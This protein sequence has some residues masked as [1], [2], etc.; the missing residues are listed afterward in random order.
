MSSIL[1]R[2]SY[3]LALDIDERIQ[4]DYGCKLSAEDFANIANVLRYPLTPVGQNKFFTTLNQLSPS[5]LSEKVSQ[6]SALINALSAIK[7]NRR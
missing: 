2:K 1:E 5:A 4:K 6:V 7:R 3:K